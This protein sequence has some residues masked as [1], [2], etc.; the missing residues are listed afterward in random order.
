[1]ADIKTN[2]NMLEGDKVELGIEVPGQEVK[3]QVDKAI[4]EIGKELKMPGFRPGKIPRNIIVT[5]IGKEAIYSQTL[6]EALPVWY[7][8]AINT[9]GI[10]PIDKPEID[11]K[12]LEDEDK[13]FG[14]KVTVAVMPT[15][16]LGKYTGIE[17][18]KETAEVADADWL[19]SQRLFIQPPGQRVLCLWIML[20]RDEFFSEA[21]VFK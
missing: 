19:A 15:P 13:P 7:E 8:T 11:V 21:Q 14:F 16:K 1:M 10:K 9:S 20:D 2:V 12:P 17:A 5:R 18:E 4:R 3:A 6:E